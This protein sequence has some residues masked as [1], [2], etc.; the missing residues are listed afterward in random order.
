MQYSSSALT[1]GN[2]FN[3][4]F[5]F[6]IN[7][8]FIQIGTEPYLLNYLKTQFHLFRSKLLYE[9]IWVDWA[10]D[11]VN[12]ICMSNCMRTLIGSLVTLHKI[13]SW[14]ALET[15]VFQSVF[16]EEIEMGKWYEIEHICL[17]EHT[18]FTQW[19]ST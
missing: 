17:I 1:S 7:Y 5:T 6:H 2:N 13:V 15:K 8:Q 9:Y 10:S 18:E 12:G 14:Q 3:C 16:W 4:D 19:K 11:M